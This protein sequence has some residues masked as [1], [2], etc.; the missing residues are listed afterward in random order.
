LK[1]VELI[2]ERTEWTPPPPRYTADAL[3]PLRIEAVDM[4]L[5]YQVKAAG[6]RWNP[7]KKLWLVKYGNIAGT[8]LERHIH[9]DGS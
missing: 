3:V 6:G 9:I 1:T 8:P 4:Q 5:R 2:V 7:E